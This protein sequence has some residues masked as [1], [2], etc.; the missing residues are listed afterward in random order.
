MASCKTKKATG[1]SKK[2][3]TKC[4]TKKGGCKKEGVDYEFMVKNKGDYIANVTKKIN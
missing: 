4:S 2:G 1:K 3:A